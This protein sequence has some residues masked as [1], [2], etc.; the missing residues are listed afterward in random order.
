MILLLIVPFDL[1]GTTTYQV[2]SRSIKEGS[3]RLSEHSSI[4]EALALAIDAKD[5]TT[6]G[7]VRRV[8][9]YSLGIAHGLGLSESEEAL[10][11]RIAMGTGRLDNIQ[12]SSSCGVRS[13]G[14]LPVLTDSFKLLVR[15]GGSG[16]KPIG[17]VLKLDDQHVL[18]IHA[19]GPGWRD[20]TVLR[21]S[22]R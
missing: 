11:R 16:L 20:K 21:I 4:I 10:E 15:V 3:R 9:A 6:H 7:R 8:Q 13:L 22:C 12:A 19:D 17:F 14:C 5:H 18:A 2:Y 1:L